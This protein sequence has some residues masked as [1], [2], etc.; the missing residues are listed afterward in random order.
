MRT[1][2][3]SEK[4]FVHVL[5]DSFS[6]F[7]LEFES[8]SLHSCN[9]ELIPYVLEQ[10]RWQEWC[11]RR[12][13][14]FTHSLHFKLADST[15]FRREHRSHLEE[16]AFVRFVRTG[17][18]LFFDLLQGLVSSAVQLELEDVDIVGSFYNTI[19][20]L[21][22]DSHWPPLSRILSSPRCWG[23]PTNMYSCPYCSP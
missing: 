5:M 13:T 19:S 18:T 20:S 8:N 12:V 16:L 21:I 15:C 2:E 23:N 6:P 3:A 17:I 14:P 4:S 10:M 1:I 11:N 7:S 22:S 9:R